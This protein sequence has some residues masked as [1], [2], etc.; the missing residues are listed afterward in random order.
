[1]SLLDLADRCEKASTEEQH[2]AIL[3]AWVAVFGAKTNWHPFIDVL[4]A[5][6]F[7]DAA[8]SL[9]PED[10]TAWEIA[11]RRRKTRF[12]AD[13]SRLTECDA[14]DEDWAHGRGSTPA[15]ALCAAALRAHAASSSSPTTTTDEGTTNGNA[16]RP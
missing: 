12:A 7:L 13:L 3:D 16:S 1:V 11:S 2:D 10:W 15:L 6:G 4:G 5:G 8:M 9:V 14:G